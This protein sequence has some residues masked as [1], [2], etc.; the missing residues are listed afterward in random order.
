MLTGGTPGPADQRIGDFER[1]NHER[2]A[3]ARTTMEEVCRLPQADIAA[4]SVVLR[5]LRSI[6]H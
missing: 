6:V 5:S 2:V 4:L 3:R 1:F